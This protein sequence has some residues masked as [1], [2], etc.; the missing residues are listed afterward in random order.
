MTHKKQGANGEKKEQEHM[1]NK[2]PKNYVMTIKNLNN[3]FKI[4]TEKDLHN[5]KNTRKS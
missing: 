1:K 5:T 4:K 3:L 2:P